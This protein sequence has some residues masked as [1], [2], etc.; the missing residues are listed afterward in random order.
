MGEIYGEKNK[1]EK[2]NLH[3]PSIYKVYSNREILCINFCIVQINSPSNNF[4]YSVEITITNTPSFCIY[5]C[6][7]FTMKTTLKRFSYTYE[8]MI[9]GSTYNVTKGV[10]TREKLPNNTR[11][12]LNAHIYIS[13]SMYFIV[14]SLWSL[15]RFSFLKYFKS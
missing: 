3:L 8:S 13:F 12:Y 11:Q 1:F 14:S 15:Y 5:I 2:R 7:K 6:Y 10:K 9:K 4:I